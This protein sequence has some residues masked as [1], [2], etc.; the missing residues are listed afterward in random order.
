MD[1]LNQLFSVYRQA[2]KNK[3]KLSTQLL[4]NKKPEF[5]DILEIYVDNSL[6]IG[7]AVSESEAILM[8]EFWELA[9]HTD[10]IVQI[11]HAIADKW[12]IET[13]KRL[14]L[15]PQIKY[16]IC[17]TLDK[18]DKTILKDIIIEGKSVPAE[19]SGPKIPPN[20]KDPRM[21]F[22]LE[23]L[24]KTMLVNKH[25]FFE[26]EEVV[27]PFNFKNNLFK[28][29]KK[30]A[31]DGQKSF[32]KDDAVILVNP[33]EIVI[34]VGDKNIGK[35]IK[36]YLAQEKPIV[37]FEGIIEIPTFVITSK[38]II[39]NPHSVVDLLNIEIY[40]DRP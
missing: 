4:S 5:G 34:D 25:L 36:I 21:K 1:F 26:E 37:L 17:C 38:N 18:K 29:E 22:K 7:V 23:E 39:K 40:N 28:S 14:Y 6:I 20:P 13:D 33:K 19:K 32:K 31:A 12:I 3:I 2:N 15:T 8:S 27:I 9:T 16:N 24:K 35:S 11:K 10:F 30:A